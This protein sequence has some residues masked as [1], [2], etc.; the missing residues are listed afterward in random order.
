MFMRH[1]R[2]PTRA[3]SLF[4]CED[5]DGTGSIAYDHEDTPSKVECPRCEGEGEVYDAARAYDEY[6][7]ACDDA[8]DTW[9]DER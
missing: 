2:K 5:C 3:D 1:I 6:E 8:Y 4:E 9:K 7:A